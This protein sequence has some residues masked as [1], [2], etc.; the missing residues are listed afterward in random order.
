MTA[1]DFL[2][3]AFAAFLLAGVAA[4]FWLAT[5]QVRHVALHRGEVPTPFRERISLAAHQKAAD[6]TITKTRFGILEMAFG[7]ALLLGWTLLGG[8][9]ALNQVLLGWFGTGMA[10]QMALVVA[11]VVI[12]ALIDLP[13]S[14]YQT[15][16]IE[17]RF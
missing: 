4:K 5:R 8:L 3:L 7:A 14:L 17:E 1:S 11:F 2:T 10:Q 16:V 13:F 9:H 12:G 15:F 6:Y